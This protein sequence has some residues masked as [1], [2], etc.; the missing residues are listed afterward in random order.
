MAVD[1]EAAHLLEVGRALSWQG[2][3][4]TGC[5]R[6]VARSVPGQRVDD[7]R[8][9]G[10]EVAKIG[11]RDAESLLGCERRTVARNHR[12]RRVFA[13]QLDQAGKGQPIRGR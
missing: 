7:G 1:V 5:A 8:V 9:K 13:K 11:L 12:L 6:L 2:N 10:A 4:Q 3:G